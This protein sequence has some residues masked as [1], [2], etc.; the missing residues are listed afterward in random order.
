VSSFHLQGPVPINS[1]AYVERSF[2]QN[3]LQNILNG[4]WVLLL[5]PRQHGKTSSLI[6]IQEQLHETG[7]ACVIVDLQRMPPCGSYEEV[8][9]WFAQVIAHALQV[10]ITQ[11]PTGYASRQLESWLEA[12]IPPGRESLVIMIDEASAILNSEWRNSF[13]GQIRS[14]ATARATAKPEELAARLQFVF[15]GSFRHETMVSNLNSPFNVCTHIETED[16]TLENAIA[17]NQQVTEHQDNVFVTQAYEFVGGQPYLLQSILSRIQSVSDQDKQV[18]FDDAITSLRNDQDNHFD[19]VFRHIIAEAGLTRLVSL[20]VRDGGIQNEPANADY[21]FLQILGI[22]RRDGNFLVFR[23]RL[24]Q[25]FAS[26]SSQI[27]QDANNIQN[28]S[29]QIVP[30]QDAYLFMRSNELR[31]IAYAMELGAVRAYNSGSYRLALA[32]FGS[33]LEAVL[34]DWLSTLSNA[35]LT[36]AINAA[37]IDRRRDFWRNENANQPDTWRLVN[38]IRVAGHVNNTIRIVDPPQALREWRNLIHPSAARQNYLS[39]NQLEPE[40]RTASGLLA[41]VR[42]DVSVVI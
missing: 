27:I 33:A 3:V 42:R 13:Y 21:K 30:A 22:A 35:T 10:T 9:E 8:I 32:G 39:E 25:E 17:L 24:Y 41:S 15:A 19:G 5:G 4:N 28:P 26:N 36:R 7:F 14:I 11:K 1:E 37:G 29:P 12:A 20:M 40:A 6:R 38:L 23:N 16:F 18:A 2:E 31:E 34:I